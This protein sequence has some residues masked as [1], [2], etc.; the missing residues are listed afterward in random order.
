M[1]LFHTLCWSWL[2][3]VQG[4]LLNRAWPEEGILWVEWMISWWLLRRHHV[5]PNPQVK[6]TGLKTMVVVLSCDT[7]WCWRR[8][9]LSLDTRG[10]LEGQYEAE[11]SRKLRYNWWSILKTD[12]VQDSSSPYLLSPSLS[13]SSCAEDGTQGRYIWGKYAQMSYSLL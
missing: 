8:D 11:S 9:I 10:I 5:F 7:S 6:L 1:V 4:L 13:F 12:S 2:E 3:A